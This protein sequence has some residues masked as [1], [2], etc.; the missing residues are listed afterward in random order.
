LLRTLAGLQE[1]HHGSLVRFG[2]P[3]DGASVAKRVD[4]RVGLVFQDPEDQFFGVTVLEDLVWGLVQHGLEASEAEAP[5]RAILLTLGLERLTDRPVQRLSFGERKRVAL[6]SA[7]V[8]QPTLLLL[9]EPTM[10]LDEVAAGEVIETVVRATA[11]MPVSVIWA[12]HDLETVPD[13]CQ[14]LLLLRQGQVVYDGDRR[15]GMQDA[16]LIGAGLRRG[17]AG[18]GGPAVL[19]LRS[20]LTAGRRSC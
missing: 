16:V 10:G 17:G 3:V 13:R 2:L 9:D 18:R 1:G 6:A 5:A 8:L 12:T 15:A 7:L 19:E 20:P 4:R 14:R 11:G